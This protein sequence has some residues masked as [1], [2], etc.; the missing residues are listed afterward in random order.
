MSGKNYQQL[1]QLNTLSFVLMFVPIEPA[2]T[3][4]AQSGTDLWSE[5]FE[6]NIV[7]VTTSTLL[8]TLTT[9][10]SIWRQERQNKNAEEIAR[11]GSDL[12]DKLVGFIDDLLSLGRKL[13]DAKK[14]V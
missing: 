14:I 12:Y 8:A 2:Y 5:A 10:S 7:V 6:K 9:V 13:D 4:A 3:L 1:Y 11:Q